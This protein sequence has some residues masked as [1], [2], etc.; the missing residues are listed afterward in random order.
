STP[1][2]AGIP[3]IFTKWFKKD[4]K[5]FVFEVRDLWPELPKALGMKNPFLLRGMSILEKLSYRKADAC[6]GLSPGICE[7]I[8][9][10][11][12]FGKKI[13]MIPNGA[14][15]DLFYKGDRVNLQLSGIKPTDVVAIFTGAHGIANGLDA[16]LNAAAVLK[17]KNREDIIL[18]FIGD[19]KLKTELVARVKKENLT[20][21]RFYDP[22]P[23]TE[24][25]KI[26]ASA[27]I[28]L[29]ILKNVP[30]FYYGTSPN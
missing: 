5:K 19:G 23:K 2:T 22:V 12:Q 10:R 21:C 6:I 8:A 7:G 29:M 30:A 27:D 17:E 18:A 1:L 20:N 3:G 14:D 24:L 13:T 15:I 4:K 9:K 25:T 28:G 26:M 11:A 16:V